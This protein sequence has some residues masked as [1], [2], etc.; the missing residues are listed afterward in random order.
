MGGSGP[1]GADNVDGRYKFDVRTDTSLCLA[2]SQPTHWSTDITMDP[3]FG[4]EFAQII[5]GSMTEELQ[6]AIDDRALVRWWH[7]VFD[8]VAWGRVWC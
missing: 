5:G 8:V 3:M 1:A 6:G 4:R 7:V 2:R